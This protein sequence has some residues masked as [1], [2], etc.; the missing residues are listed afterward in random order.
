MK[1]GK[2]I[3]RAVLCSILFLAVVT[4]VL[5]LFM[6]IQIGCDGY[7]GSMIDILITGIEK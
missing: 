5:L 1:F 6:S 7:E 3:K 4:L 2:L